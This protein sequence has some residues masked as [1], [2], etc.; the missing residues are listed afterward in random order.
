MSFKRLKAFKTEDILPQ[1]TN[2]CKSCDKRVGPEEVI[3]FL[4]EIK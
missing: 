2:Q 4:N 1:I 3:T